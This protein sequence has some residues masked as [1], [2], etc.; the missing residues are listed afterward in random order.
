MQLTN[1][2]DDEK[3][4]VAIRV[5]EIS[6]DSITPKDE[7]YEFCRESIELCRQWL[8][9]KK[10]SKVDILERAS[11]HGRAIA[12]IVMEIEDLELANKYGSILICV[13]YIGWQAYNYEE[14]YFYPQD[15]ESM[16]DEELET[17]IEELIE[18]GLLREQDLETILGG[19]NKA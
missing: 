5:A 10:I 4:K 8:Q 13:L 19:G 11:S 3:C 2:T 7:N 18:E 14:D 17:L 1:Y 12:D 6:L 9:H 15:L 16:S